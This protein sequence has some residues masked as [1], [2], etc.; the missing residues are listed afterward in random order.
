MVPMAWISS[1][2]GS[3]SDGITLGCQENGLLLSMASSS[4]L[5]DLARPTSKCRIMYGKTTMPR[6]GSSG[7]IRDFF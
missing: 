2:P 6:S 5:I 4:A 7:M 1:G 3:S